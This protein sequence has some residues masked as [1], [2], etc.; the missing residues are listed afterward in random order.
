[1]QD[2]QPWAGIA[3]AGGWNTSL[4]CLNYNLQWSKKEDLVFVWAR[5]TDY[6]VGLKAAGKFLLSQK[7]L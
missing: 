4:E 2:Q 3:E 1:M 7:D 6:I 5:L